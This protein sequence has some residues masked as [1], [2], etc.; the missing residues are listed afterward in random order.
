M[1][2]GNLVQENIQTFQFKIV[3]I[4]ED[5]KMIAL[6]NKNVNNEPDFWNIGRYIE[7]YKSN[8]P[9]RSRPLREVAINYQMNGEWAYY[10]GAQVTNF[11][12]IPEGLTPISIP[13]G[14][15]LVMSFNSNSNDDL[16]NNLVGKVINVA[17]EYCN[18]YNIQIDESYQPIE[19]Y[20]S[21]DDGST[22]PKE[23]PEMDIWLRLK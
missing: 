19:A 10:F 7:K 9:N 2:G 3:T 15:F 21:E 11:D 17:K 5:F 12:I 16:L 18:L 6:S 20:N 22:E 1:D 14:K 8:M 13:A 23:W 4:T